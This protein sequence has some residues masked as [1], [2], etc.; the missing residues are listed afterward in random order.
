VKV[1]VALNTPA[2]TSRRFYRTFLGLEP[3][4]LSPATRGSTSQNRLEPHAERLEPN[5]WPGALNHLG[6]QSLRPGLSKKRQSGSRLRGWRRRGGEHRLLLCVTG[7]G[8]GDGSQWLSV[9]GVRREGRGIRPRTS[10]RRLK[11]VPNVLSRVNELLELFDYN[12]WAKPHDLRRGRPD[13]R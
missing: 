2:L 1:H 10:L 8:L 4:K 9:G 12:A 7:Q 13:S 6:I 3:L 11:P 5:R